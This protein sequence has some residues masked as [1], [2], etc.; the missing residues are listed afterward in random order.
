MLVVLHPVGPEPPHVYWR[1]RLVVLGLLGLVLLALWWLFGGDDERVTTRTESTAADLVR[2]PTADPS[3][4]PTAATTPTA[5]PT[6]A[7]R[8]RGTPSPQ[9]RTPS[10]CRNGDLEVDVAADAR[11][12]RRGTTPRFTVSVTNTGRD[13]CKLDVGPR[14]V[15]LILTSGGQPTWSSDDCRPAGDSDVRVLG[16]RER[17]RTTV[18][19]PRLRTARG[20]DRPIARALPGTYVLVGQIGGVRGGYAVITLL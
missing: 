19:W 6:T 9:A 14:S 18:T 20:C 11:A 10:L 13:R 7:P 4:G 2:R 8:G 5:T 1:R 16:P 12:Y 17:W 15:E 3:V